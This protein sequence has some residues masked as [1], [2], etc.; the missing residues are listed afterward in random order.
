MARRLTESL[1]NGFQQTL[2][3]EDSEPR[4]DRHLG[5][6]GKL[7][8]ELPLEGAAKEIQTSAAAPSPPS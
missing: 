8:D 4:E 3:V 5:V 7:R 1:F 6:A 2:N